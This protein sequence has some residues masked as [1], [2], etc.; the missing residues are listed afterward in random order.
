MSVILSLIIILAPI[1]IIYFG[2][3]A[4]QH[5]IIIRNA[6]RRED[7]PPWLINSIMDANGPDRK[8]GVQ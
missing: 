2:V 1:G 4:L 7:A 3:K 8:W 6:R 5:T